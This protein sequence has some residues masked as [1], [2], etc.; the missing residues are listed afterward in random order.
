[1]GKC[2]KAK[3]FSLKQNQSN[4]LHCSTRIE[5]KL[6]ALIT[7]RVNWMISGQVMREQNQG[8]FDGYRPFNYQNA[9]V[10]LSSSLKTVTPDI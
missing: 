3:R 10:T 7:G 9:I 6:E 8:I 4:C 5:H 2:Y 1:M